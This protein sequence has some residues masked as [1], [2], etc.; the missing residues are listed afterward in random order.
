MNTKTTSTTEETQIPAI[1]QFWR[2][3]SLQLPRIH[4]PNT[5]L[6]VSFTILS[7]LFLISVRMISIQ[8]LERIFGWPS[9]AS[10]EGAASLAG[11]VHSSL[12]CPGLVI[13]FVTHTYSPSEPLAKAPKWWQELVDSLLQ[14]CT[15]YMVYDA[16]FIL[17]NRWD[18]SVSWIPALQGDDI[19][20]LGHHVATATYMTQTRIYQAGHMSAMMC[21][22]IGEASNPP[23]NTWFIT[24]KAL[25]LDC[26]NG[27]V[28]QFVHKYNEVVFCVIYLLLR[29][30]VGPLVCTHMSYDLLF[31]ENAKKH[32][33]LALRLF[34]NFMIWMVIVGSY[35]WIVYTHEL[36]S[37]HLYGSEHEL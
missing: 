32:L 18:P 15:G 22:L 5:N 10:D 19:L 3:L 9:G 21:M 36:L 6:N 35:S 12:L 31:S 2:N 30:L 26:C 37:K 7:A 34:W 25:K 28:M 14:F 27:I 20:F 4:I 13:A 8:I 16:S 17:A 29:V 23:M 1:A 24:S 11:I 33:P